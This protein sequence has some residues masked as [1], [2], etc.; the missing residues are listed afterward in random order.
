MLPTKLGSNFRQPLNF[1]IGHVVLCIQLVQ[2]YVSWILDVVFPA[3]AKEVSGIP[4][5]AVEVFS[6]ASQEP[7]PTHPA[8]NH[9]APLNMALLIFPTVLLRRKHEMIELLIPLVHL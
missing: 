1:S 4:D 2:G 6:N 9:R 7:S 8:A 5:I 3:I